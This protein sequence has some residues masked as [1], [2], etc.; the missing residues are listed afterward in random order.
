[1]IDTIKIFTMINKS[2]FDIIS[3]NSIIKTAFKSSDGTIFYTIINDK[4]EGSYSSSLS[5][6]VG[7]GSK[8]HFVN[9]Y[10]LEIEGSF[11]KIKKG[12]NSFNG[13]YN[14]IDIS[15]KLINLVSS[16]YNVKLP[17]LKNWF[18]Q[19]CDIAICYDLNNNKNV[20]D[21]INSLSMCNYPRRNLKFYQDESLY[22]SGS[23]TTLK[24]YNKLIEFK[25]HDLSK[26]CSSSF[27]LS[28]YLDVIDGF[29]RFECEIKKKKLSAFYNKKYVRINQV[30]Y[31]DLKN[32]W[33][34]EFM[35]LLKM[36]E[37][38][39]TKV[40]SKKD[41]L[42]RL[43]VLY[44][45]NKDFSLPSSK[46]F[47]LYNFYCSVMVDGVRNVRERVSKSVYYR[48]IKELKNANIDFSQN[49]DLDF[50]EA[51]FQFNPFDY[52]EVV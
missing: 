43:M 20:R 47:R 24:I 34:D 14:I 42:A 31:K 18:L 25:K 40:K 22:L 2:T 5:V 16:H 7:C 23:S 6:R 39:L 46:A 36:F 33:G 41:V 30:C 21:Y 13:F 3:N 19:R 52:E 15:L 27:N 4:L 10:Y 38:D 48:N 49:M 45:N 26:F 50:S 1:M 51:V 35:K 32:I 29:V 9:M 8:Y 11:H 12:Y 44:P 17:N 28:N 37:S